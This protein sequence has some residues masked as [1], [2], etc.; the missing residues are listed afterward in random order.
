[1]ILADGSTVW[2]NKAYSYGAGSGEAEVIFD[3][4]FTVMT[5]PDT[6]DEMEA[7]IGDDSIE[8]QDWWKSSTNSETGEDVTV[9]YNSITLV[10]EYDHT[11]EHHDDDRVWGDADCDGVVKMNDAVLV[12]QS[13]SNGDRFV[14]DGSEE[15]HITPEGKKN[16]DVSKDGEGITPKD[17]LAIQKYLL[18]IIPS[19]PEK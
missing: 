14:E 10:Y 5:G 3:G 9:T 11:G 19:L 6:S 16:A 1:M 17:A 13:L 7:K 12:M 18:K 15:N 4:T 8:F 2:G